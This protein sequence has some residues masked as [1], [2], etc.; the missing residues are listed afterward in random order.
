MQHTPTTIEEAVQCVRQLSRLQIVG[1]GTKSSLTQPIDRLERL[2]TTSLSGVTE[3]ES[4]EFLVTALAGTTLETVDAVLAEKGQYLPFD[5][6]L[7][8]RGATIGGTISS[9]LSGSGRLKYGGLRDFLMGVRFI[10]GRGNLVTGGGHVVKNAAGYDL[11]KLVAG[12]CGSLALLVEVT[13]KV[14]PRPSHRLPLRRTSEN[15]HEAMQL[16]AELT[17]SPLDITAIDISP[18]GIIDVLLTGTEPANLAT[19][20]R[21]IQLTGSKWQQVDHEYWNTIAEWADVEAGE[22]L[23]RVPLAP[24][25]VMKFDASMHELRVPRRYSAAGNVAWV[26][27]PASQPIRTLD[28]SL[29]HQHLG[30]TILTGT[31]ARCRLG[32]RPE[33]ELMARLQRAFDPDQRFVGS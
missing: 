9:N 16:C 15:L 3:Y 13:I 33:P 7:L 28:E 26:R 8:K 12:C 19:R 32:R 1:A 10:D 5:P 2:I 23:T 20:D 21:L 22:R 11:P 17:R 30:G 4:G 29:L 6:P 27:W 25:L 31:A 24:S 14:L 18:S